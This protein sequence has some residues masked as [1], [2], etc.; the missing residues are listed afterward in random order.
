MGLGLFRGWK[1]FKNGCNRLKSGHFA[2]TPTRITCSCMPQQ[3][4]KRDRARCYRGA[5]VA[6]SHRLRLD[7]FLPPDFTG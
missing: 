6:W 5:F 3:A 1:S 7:F 2:F 4:L